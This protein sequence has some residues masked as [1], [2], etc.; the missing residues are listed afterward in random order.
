[1]VKKMANVKEPSEEGAW[2]SVYNYVKDRIIKGAYG[3]GERL[4]EREISKLVNVSRTPTREA[5][6]ILE[7]EGYVTN[8][9]NRGAVVKKYSPEDLETIQKMLSLLEGLAVKLAIPKLTKNDIATLKKMTD[10][11]WKIVMEEENYLDYLTLNFDFHLYFPKVVGNRELLDTISHLRGRIFRVYYAHMML[12]RNPEQFIKDH[13]ELV[14]AL[15]GKIKK[16]PEKIM[17]E[18]VNRSRKS[19]FGFHQSLG[20]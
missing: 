12:A 18:H 5:L 7:F 4:N 17:E 13:Q 3:P 16:R 9:T 6:R 2:V 20:L 11:L 15:E 10:K 19:L 14:D 1:M 8:Y